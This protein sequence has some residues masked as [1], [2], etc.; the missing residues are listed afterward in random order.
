MQIV[1][2]LCFFSSEKGITGNACRQVDGSFFYS[3]SVSMIDF[4]EKDT[5]ING[6]YSA[7]E[8]R[9]LK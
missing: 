9:K 4:L 8:L 6:Q 7:S 3:K 1:E 2:T 5:T